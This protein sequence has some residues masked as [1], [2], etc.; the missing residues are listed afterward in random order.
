MADGAMS[1]AERQAFLEDVHV[2]VLAVD[3]PGRGPWSLPIW[4][5]VEDGD[6]LMS[7]ALSS[8]KTT[9]LRAAGRATLT[10]QDEAPPYKYAAFEGPV[11][12]EPGPHDVL[13][14]AARYLG[15][16]LGEL[17]ADA[18]PNTEDSA[19]ARLT[20]ESWNTMDFAKLLGL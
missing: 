11:V 15:P 19:V 16:E 2:G 7:L 10:I 14:L 9:L 20:P 13:A 8:L 6:V 18:N 4:Y 1:D 5:W 3:R 17:Y 12:V